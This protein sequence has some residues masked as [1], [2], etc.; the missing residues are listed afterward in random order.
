MYTC[1]I[2]TKN[3]TRKDNLIRHLRKFHDN[4]DSLKDLLKNLETMPPRKRTR[5]EVS[6]SENEEGS[7]ASVS[8]SEDEIEDQ[9]NGEDIL[10]PSMDLMKDVWEI[11]NDYADRDYEGDVVRAYIDQVRIARR[12]KKNAVHKKVMETV[13]GLQERDYNM[14]FEE[15][16]LKAANRRKYII[17][18]AAKEA[19][20]LAEEEEAKET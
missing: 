20:E 5:D 1:D 10:T 6:D 2:C 17:E 9:L 14:D 16:L 4:G 3:F 13:A 19:I 12:L 8:S 11:I 18:Q 7:I 15:A